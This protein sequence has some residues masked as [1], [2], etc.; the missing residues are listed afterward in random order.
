MLAD[1]AKARG[2][3]AMIVR[4]DRDDRQTRCRQ[5]GQARLGGRWTPG[6]LGEAELKFV[7][8]K[9]GR[10][11]KGPARFAVADRRRGPSPTRLS[12]RRPTRR[13]ARSTTAWPQD[14]VHAR[15]FAP[16]RPGRKPSGRRQIDRRRGNRWFRHATTPRGPIFPT[17][18][19][20]SPPTSSGD[21]Y[22]V[23]FEGLEGREQMKFEVRGYERRRPDPSGHRARRSASRRTSRRS[24]IRDLA[25]RYRKAVTARGDHLSGPRIEQGDSRRPVSG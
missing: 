6:T 2:G 25:H 16:P 23:T 22:D 4:Y 11:G 17:R 21:A 14:P 5:P 8:A 1:C 15:S 7:C 10:R 20:L 13:P 12:R 3:W 19:R 18:R 24:T 9:A